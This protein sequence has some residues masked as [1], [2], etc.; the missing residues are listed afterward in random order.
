MSTKI[1]AKPKL[2]NA[3]FRVCCNH[4]NRRAC[5]KTVD[6]IRNYF[7]NIVEL[8]A[9]QPYAKEDDM[10]VIGTAIIDPQKKIKFQ[11]DL[12]KLK[13]TADGTRVIKKAVVEIVQ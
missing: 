5:V 9:T 6:A 1:I 7:N 13:I 12:K 4:T 3:D 2:V 10:C 11:K 8:T